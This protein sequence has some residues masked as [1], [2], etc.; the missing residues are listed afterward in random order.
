[1]VFLHWLLPVSA[2]L[3]ALGWAWQVVDR[4]LHRN[5]VPDLNLLS[6]CLPLK[7]DAPHLTVIVPACNE[8]DGIETTLR[9][10]LASRG[11]RLQILAVNDRSTDATGARMEAIAAE[12]AADN[13]VGGHTLEVI[14]IRE[15]PHGWLGKPHALATAARRAQAKWILFTDG[16]VEFASEVLVRALG[17]AQREQV[18]HLAVLPDWVAVS[19]AEMA[20]Q[21]AMFALTGW[22]LRY[23]K[24]ADPKAKDFLGVG[25]FNLMRKASYEALGGFETLRMEVLE[26]LRMG[27]RVK[28]FGMRQQVAWGCG[29]V[30]VRWANGA[31]GVV[32]NLE[33]NIFALFRFQMILALAACA[34]MMLHT[35]WPLLA[36]AAGGTA[37]VAGVSTYLALAAVYALQ[38]RRTHVPA[39]YVLFFPFAS[40]LFLFAMLRSITMTILRN[41]VVWRGTHY[42]LRELRA[43]A[44]D[45]W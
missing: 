31:W 15:L 12:C 23:W 24:I 14:H 5:S 10:L 2:W 19:R 27:W 42:P 25:A 37:R 30:R 33:K 18:D 28:Q 4:W 7:A 38:Q 17:F 6:E 43:A 21:G 1:M 32:R 22:G 3:L 39:G 13:A 41:G 35:V 26:D 45:R 8:Q 20:L 29:M 11:L 40:A 9:G 16:D 34:G 44:G 36:I